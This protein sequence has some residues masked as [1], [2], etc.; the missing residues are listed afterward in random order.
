MTHI[1]GKE[2]VLRIYKELLQISMK[3]IV[4]TMG[5]KWVKDLKDIH[6]KKKIQV[7]NKFDVETCSNSVIRELLVNNI[8]T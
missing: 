3:H 8:L 6:Y 7:T 1:S 4:S 5:K 2:L